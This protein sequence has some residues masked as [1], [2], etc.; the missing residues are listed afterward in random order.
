MKV[1]CFGDSITGPR[2]REAYRD[3]YLKYSDLLQLMLEARHGIGN[4]VVLNR[5]FAGDKT[6]ADAQAGTPGAINRLQQDVL[7]EQP[8]IVTMLIG[9]NDP[10]DTAAERAVT[11]QHLDAIV[12]AVQQLPC[13]LLV[14]QYH[15]LPNPEHPETAWHGLDD[16]N[17]LIAEV[18]AAHHVPLLDMSVPMRAALATM[19]LA[20]LVNLTDGV[21]LNPHGEMIFAEAI[22]AKLDAL[23]W[24][25]PLK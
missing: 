25:I 1:V 23:Q 6:Y 10:K 13:K 12:T 21:H 7:D 19:P 16:N 15:V 17:E 9:G 24:I 5:G 14:M 20:E 18:A 11:R 2:P 8:D 22:F 3:K 4:V